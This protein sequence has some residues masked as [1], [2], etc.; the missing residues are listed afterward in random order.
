MNIYCNGNLIYT[1]VVNHSMSLDEALDIVA[2]DSW[3]DEVNENG[4][5][6]DEEVYD[7]DIYYDDLEIE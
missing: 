3:R 1:V 4:Y 5:F 6:R 2:P 7:D